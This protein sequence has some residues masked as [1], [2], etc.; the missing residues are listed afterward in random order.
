MCSENDGFFVCECQK[1]KEMKFWETNK[2]CQTPI[3][4]Y[5]H[6]QLDKDKKF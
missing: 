1:I 4:I 3:K 6:L 2:K 5:W